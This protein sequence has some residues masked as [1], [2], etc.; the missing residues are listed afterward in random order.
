M[1]VLVVG[2]G[3][4]EHA[5]AWKLVRSPSVGGVLAAPGNAGIA[6]VAECFPVESTD[7]PGIASLAEAERVDLTVVGPEAPLVA[8]LVDELR[9]R[10]LR[11]FGPT[12]DGA[13]I[14]G[15]KVWAKELC[16]K[17]G[18]PTAR[19]EITDDITRAVMS[20]DVFDPP[21]VIKAD[22]LAAGKGVVL[23]PLASWPSKPSRRAWWSGSLAP[24]GIGC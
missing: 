3:G 9:R 2:G 14:E 5:L 4:R 23:A 12:A 22:G 16:L 21:Y 19:A 15:S 1:R 18:I 20:L 8:G 11:A 10:G 13:R 24:R 6:E 17:Y 7:V